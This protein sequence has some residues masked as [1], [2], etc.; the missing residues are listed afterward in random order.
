LPDAIPT[1]EQDYFAYIVG[2]FKKSVYPDPGR[3]Q[4]PNLVVD[5]CP[6][7]SN[8]RKRFQP[9]ILIKQWPQL[10]PCV[11]IQIPREQ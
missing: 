6:F 9:G 1:Q 4:Y 7:Y 8:H 5:S 3:F 11:I 2:I 10:H